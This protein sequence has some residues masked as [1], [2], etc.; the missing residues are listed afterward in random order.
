MPNENFAKQKK[1]SYCRKWALCSFPDQTSF[2]VPW[3][4]T[5]WFQR[6]GYG[7]KQHE[8]QNPHLNPLTKQN[9]PH[10]IASYESYKAAEAPQ[11]AD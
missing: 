11:A 2:V 3:I 6:T 8:P 5:K 9:N 7:I 4:R 10:P 1:D